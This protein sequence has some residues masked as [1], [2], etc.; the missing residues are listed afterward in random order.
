MVVQPASYSPPQAGMNPAA[1][2]SIPTV[3]P[4]RGLP[5]KSAPGK[6]NPAQAQTLISEADLDQIDTVT[7]QALLSP[8]TMEK[9]LEAKN[10]NLHSPGTSKTGPNP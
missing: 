8:Q 9:I 2:D 3:T 6:T 4:T 5:G 1:E 10:G 7:T